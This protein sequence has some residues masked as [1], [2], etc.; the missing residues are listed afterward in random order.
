MIQVAWYAAVQVASFARDCAQRIIGTGIGDQ[1]VALNRQ[2]I[3]TI[4]LPQLQGAIDLASCTST[5]E[6]SGDTGEESGV[7]PA[8]DPVCFAAYITVPNDPHL[9]IAAGQG[10]GSE[11]PN[12]DGSMPPDWRCDAAE[13]SPPGVGGDAANMGHGPFGLR[14]TST[15]WYRLPTGT[16]L[17]TSPPGRGHCGTA[18][19]GWLSGWPAGAVGHPRE[20]Y[21][22]PADGSL[23]PPVGSPPAAGFVCFDHATSH[24]DSCY[25]SAPVRAV[26]CGAFVLWELPPPPFYSVHCYG[27]C[28]A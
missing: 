27:Y 19:T 24:H 22:T 26:S 20:H 18:I 8:A 1:I 21:N 4:A 6:S 16:S 12:F 7:D 5:T 9:S 3:A 10:G 13:G 25:S 15:A 28:V 2:C 14:Q 17:P 23:P 11:Y